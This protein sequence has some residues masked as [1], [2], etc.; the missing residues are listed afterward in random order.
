MVDVLG[1]LVAHGKMGR[2]KAIIDKPVDF[3]GGGAA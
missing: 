2:H 3:T 1:S